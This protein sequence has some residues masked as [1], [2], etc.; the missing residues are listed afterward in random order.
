MGDQAPNIPPEPQ[1]FFD[2]HIATTKGVVRLGALTLGFGALGVY[3]LS[4][5]EFRGGC[6]VALAIGFAGLTIYGA[7]EENWNAQNRAN[8]PAGPPS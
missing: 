5:N 2:R 1:G 8:P 4:Q 7:Y 6:W 3:E